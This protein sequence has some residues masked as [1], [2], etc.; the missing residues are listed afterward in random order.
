[1]PHLP[2][3]FLLILLVSLYNS[4]AQSLPPNLDSEVQRILDEFQVPGLSLAIV[5]DGEVI[6]TKGYGIKSA[7]TNDRVNEKTLFGIASNSKAFTATAIAML[8]EEGK[9][10]WND[11]VIDY[12]PWFRMSDAY[13]TKEMTV[14]D[15]LVHRSGLGLGAG[16]LLWW[17]PTNYSRQEI[18]ERVKDVPLIHS[19][20]STYAYDNVLFIIAAQLIEKVSGL[21]WE[22]FIKERMLDPMGFEYSTILGYT[23]TDRNANAGTH[24]LVEGKLQTVY[25]FLT[26][27]ANG[28]VGIN[29]CAVDMAKWM[30]VQLDSGKISNEKR[31]FSQ[32]SARHLW[33][34]ITPINVGKAPAEL[35]PSQ[36]S[37]RGYG[38]GFGVRD[39]RGQKMVSHTGGLP[40]YLSMV[41]LLPDKRLGVTVLT[42]QESGEAF[43]AL[44][45]YI[46]DFYL[47]APDFDWVAGY[48]QLKQKSLN[49]LEKEKAELQS[50]RNND[51][52]PSLPLKEY[53]GTYNDKWY[54][55]VQITENNGKLEISFSHTPL[56][57]GELV[58][59]QYDTFIAKWYEREM[60]ADAFVNFSI[61]P[62]GSV[63]C[64]KMKAAYSDADFSFD[65][66]DLILERKEEVF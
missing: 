19:F 66:H 58:H 59:W 25:P 60:R 27:N 22:Q 65:F 12:L 26:D 21:K 8:E 55:N 30:L 6:L 47:A 35:A 24:A 34:L 10:K 45:N 48:K 15:L 52:Q 28:A 36:S 23:D 64:A 49:N 1:M 2:K 39:Y 63:V 46:M 32:S 42:N 16:D 20:R 4:H 38:L 29:S 41:T 17:P 40:G 18:C 44:T 3:L 43:S 51:T 5:K 33:S 57:K 53:T 31:L 62:D 9:L 56:L 14:K 54:G 7:G 37:F 13:I 61:D 50:K 11:K